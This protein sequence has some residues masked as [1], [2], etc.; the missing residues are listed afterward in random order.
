M[1]VGNGAGMVDPQKFHVHPKSGMN[2]LRDK[3][4]V[5]LEIQVGFHGVELTD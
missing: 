5:L 2:Y 1:D 3:E 4:K